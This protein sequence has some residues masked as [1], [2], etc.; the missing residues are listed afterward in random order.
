[1]RIQ[2]NAHPKDCDRSI[3][4]LITPPL[5]YR[6]LEEKP[7]SSTPED[8][9]FMVWG[10]SVHKL[11]EAVPGGRN[12]ARMHKE[13]CGWTVGGTADRIRDDG[14]VVD[15]KT[16]SGYGMKMLLEK[17]IGAEHPEH[18]QQLEGYAWLADSPAKGFVQYI[19]RDW[20]RRSKEPLSAV[21][22]VA[23]RPMPEIAAWIVERVLAHQMA[24][25]LPLDRLSPCEDRHAFSCGPDGIPKRCAL[26][27]AANRHC[28]AYK[29]MTEAEG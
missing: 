1:V 18:V 25:K 16:I 21:S 4:Q 11:L 23:L 12:E 6:L 7:W 28:P 5:R 2:Q 19:N 24:T 15:W 13:V 14:T 9:W 10:S 26:Y 27:C 29:A 8:M 22:E 3:T 17:G 20:N